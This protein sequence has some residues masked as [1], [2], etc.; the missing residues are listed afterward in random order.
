[1]LYG[2]DYPFIPVTGAVVLAQKMKA[3]LEETFADVLVRTAI[4]SGSV[5]RLLNISE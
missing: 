3:R 1:M 4:Y 2:S 5:K